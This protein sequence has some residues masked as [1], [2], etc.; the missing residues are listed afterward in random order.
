MSMVTICA[1]GIIMSR[2]RISLTP[3]TPSIISLVCGSIS[4]R[5]SASVITSTSSCLLCGSPEKDSLSFS[6]QLLPEEP[7]VEWGLSS[8]IISV[9]FTL[10]GK[11]NRLGTGRQWLIWLKSQFPALPFLPLRRLQY[12]R[13]PVNARCRAQ[14]CGHNG[15]QWVFVALLLPGQ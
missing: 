15:E 7:L 1:L 11:V 14:S 13:S 12:G 6:N 3:M 10:L 5:C 4:S 8:L 9:I 2:T